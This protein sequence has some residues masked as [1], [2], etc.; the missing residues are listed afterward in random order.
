MARKKYQALSPDGIT[1]E[2]GVSHYTSK[3]AMFTAFDTW[4]ERFKQQ[5]YYS[6]ATYGR[7]PLEDLEEYCSF[8]IL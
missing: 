4:K 6:S 8:T 3:K 7:I 5:G 2:F 1:L